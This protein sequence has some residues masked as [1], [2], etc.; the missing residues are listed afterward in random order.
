MGAL[1]PKTAGYSQN[2][3]SS[4]DK[5]AFSQSRNNQTL[6]ETHTDEPYTQILAT[7]I[8]T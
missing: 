1:F 6:N 4:Y 8:N 3:H 5:N 2:I 7:H